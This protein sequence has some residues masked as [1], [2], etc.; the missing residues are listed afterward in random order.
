MLKFFNV[1]DLLKI[2][3]VEQIKNYLGLPAGATG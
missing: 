2:L 3:F 1:T